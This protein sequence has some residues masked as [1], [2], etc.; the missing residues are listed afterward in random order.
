MNQTTHRNGDYHPESNSVYWNGEWQSLSEVSKTPEQIIKDFV[1]LVYPWAVTARINQ[2]VFYIY[3]GE[4]YHQHTWNKL[5]H[6][7]DYLF[8]VSEALGLEHMTKEEEKSWR[9]DF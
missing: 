9:M 6:Q 3:S 4:P 2:G 1:K 8:N 5:A 7:Y